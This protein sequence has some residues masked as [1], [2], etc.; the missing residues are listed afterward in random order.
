VSKRFLE[1]LQS[2]GLPNNYEVAR[3]TI[4]SSTGKHLTKKEYFALRFGKF[5]D[6]LLHFDEASKR[7]VPNLKDCFVYDTIST[8][9]VTD[10]NI[11]FVDKPCY[12]EVVLLTEKAKIEIQKQ[13]YCPAIY[14]AAE[15]TTAYSQDNEW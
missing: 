6:D 10:R 13:F 12:Q 7:A 1:Y 15:F 2:N 4:V 5:D 3:L 9:E 8:S 14:S 11:F